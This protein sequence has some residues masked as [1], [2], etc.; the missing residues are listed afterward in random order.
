MVFCGDP[1][2]SVILEGWSKGIFGDFGRILFFRFQTASLLVEESCSPESL[3]SPEKVG[4]AAFRGVSGTLA[5]GPGLAESSPAAPDSLGSMFARHAGTW[6]R[7]HKT[8]VMEILPSEVAR[9]ITPPT[10]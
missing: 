6:W 7:E 9:K 2:A 4:I 8:A 10:F 1:G 5:A 3:V